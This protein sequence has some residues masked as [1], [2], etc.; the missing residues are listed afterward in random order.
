M[1][2]LIKFL[3]TILIGGQ[4][5]VLPIWVTV[6]LLL[7]AVNGAVAML[8]PILCRWPNTSSLSAA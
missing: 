3:K 8:C 2:T 4:V 1:K 5:I 6:L 7:K